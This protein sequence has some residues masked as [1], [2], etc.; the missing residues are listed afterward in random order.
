MT[1]EQMIDTLQANH[2]AMNRD[3]TPYSEAILVI[4]HL[5]SQVAL[6]SSQQKELDLRVHR[7]MRKLRERAESAEHV[8]VESGVVP[9]IGEMENCRCDDCR[10]VA[11]GLAEAGYLDTVSDKW[12]T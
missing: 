1:P 2:N 12:W 11:K 8:I 3:V 6:S 10:E 9:G 7:E 5:L 4:K